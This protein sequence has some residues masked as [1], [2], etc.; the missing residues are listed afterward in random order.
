MCHAVDGCPHPGCPP[1][2]PSD[3]SPLPRSAR[4]NYRGNAGL[5]GAYQTTAEYPDSGNGLLPELGRVTPAHAVDGLSHTAAVSERVRGSGP[6]ATLSPER[7]VTSLSGLRYTADDLLTAC[8]AAARA[9]K[10][11]YGGAGSFWLWT[12]REFS[13]YTHTQEPNGRIPDGLDLYGYAGYGMMTARSRHPGG[14]NVLM[15]DGSTRFF[16]E[17]ISRDVWR[18]FGTRSG[19]E[20]VD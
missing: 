4:N 17:S 12:A 11:I 8:R 20:L 2:C 9:D 15:G 18:G 10:L 16:K 5:G 14:V 13:I 7:D 1:L 19:G 3:P 6:R